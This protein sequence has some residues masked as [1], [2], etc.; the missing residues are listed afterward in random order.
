[1]I[2][3]EQVQ[4][5][6]LSDKTKV[7]LME[8]ADDLREERTPKLNGG[9]L[10]FNMRQYL[11]LNMPPET[12]DKTGHSCDTVGCLA[13]WIVAKFGT[14]EQRKSL[15]ELRKH[16]IPLLAAEILELDAEQTAA[17]FKPHPHS[18]FWDAGPISIAQGL[19]HYV[20]T[21]ELIW[22]TW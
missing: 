19:E 12:F 21:G 8:L 1:M 2:T 17:L 10:G 20:K 7:A 13:A 16:A 14:E 3:E 15:L 9:Y 22:R 5:Q 4:L 6:P 11:S 18:L